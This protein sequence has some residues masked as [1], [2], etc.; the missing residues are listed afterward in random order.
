[1]V[2]LNLFYRLCHCIVC[3]RLGAPGLFAHNE[4]RI[5]PSEENHF[6]F[7]LL[8]SKEGFANCRI[9][10]INFWEN[11][12]SL[13]ISFFFQSSLKRRAY[14]WKSIA[15]GTKDPRV[16][17]FNQIN[18]LMNH[19]TSLQDTKPRIKFRWQ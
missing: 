18:N 17:C 3:G 8:F 2:S 7:L 5:S 15:K 4:L 16:E 1:M 19:A 11:Y 10:N 13:I 9:L 12:F 6:L 14:L